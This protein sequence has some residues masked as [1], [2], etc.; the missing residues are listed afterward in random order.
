MANPKT[1]RIVIII[2][3][4][5]ALIASAFTVYYKV[6]KPGKD[7]QKKKDEE[8]KA[9]KEAE[10]K[11]QAYTP[12]KDT[13]NSWPLKLAMSGPKIKAMQSA[14]ITAGASIPAG[15][16][17]YFGSQT[18]IALKKRGYN[19]TSISQPEYNDI[20]DGKAKI[21]ATTAEPFKNGQKVYGAK[22]VKIFTKP[23][24][25]KDFFVGYIDKYELVGTYYQKSPVEGWS[26]VYSQGYKDKSGNWQ[27]GKGYVYVITS[28]LTSQSV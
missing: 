14:L 11:G 21:T 5:V 24:I 6:I 13:D 19:E 12:P 27:A 7:E 9:K 2:L 3:S 18:S 1:A 4:S 8:E 28:H 22:Q 16:T 10:A 23:D 26:K 17:G 25:A 20:I 15:A